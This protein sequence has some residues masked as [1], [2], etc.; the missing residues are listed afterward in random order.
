MSG[1]SLP[2]VADNLRRA[3]A[4]WARAAELIEERAD[5]LAAGLSA[6]ERAW[7]SP[8]GRAHADD[9]RALVARARAAAGVA[10]YNHAQLLAAAD[11]TEA[12]IRGL[13]AS[14]SSPAGRDAMVRDIVDALNETYANAAARLTE[15]RVEVGHAV[16]VLAS[17]ST[18]AP[19]GEPA[20]PSPDPAGDD[21]WSSVE[22]DPELPDLLGAGAVPVGR[23]RGTKGGGELGRFPV[24]PRPAVAPVLPRSRVVPD[25]PRSGT[26]PDQQRSGVAPDQPRSG[27]APGRPAAPA[28]PPRE[29]TYIDARG[30]QVRIRWNAASQ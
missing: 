24:T 4:D 2:V 18:S 10:R 19:S 12:A 16:S 28:S 1:E 14:S 29:E 9:V 17:A 23:S 25:Q 27:V 5:V 15:P 26:A 30:H 3:A 21:G 8:A 7:D 22:I 13:D 20:A 6:V 11:A